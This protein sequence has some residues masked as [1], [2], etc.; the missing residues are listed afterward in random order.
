MNMGDKK[1][2]FTNSFSEEIYNDTYR[3]GDEHIDDTFKRIADKMASNEKDP[4][5]WS[6]NF[7]NLLTNFK[8]VPGGRIISNAGI[9]LRGTSMINC[10]VDGFMGEDQDSMQSI[11][12]ALRR[13]ALI[14]KSEGG[15]G[16]CAD[17]MRPRGS[18]IEGIGSDSPGAVKM[19]EMWDTQSSVI[20]SGSG[21]K[22]NHKGAKGKIRKGAMMV[23]MSCWHPDIEE[24]ITAK[25]TVGRLTKFNMSVL[26]TNDFME[27][28][29]THSKWVLEFPDHEKEHDY[30]RTHWNGDINA[31]K[32]AGKA[33]VVYKTFEDANELYD[34]IMKS[35]YNRN[36]PGVL[37]VDRMNE[38][39]NLSY[40]EHINAT[41]PC[42]VGSTLVLTNIGWI[43]IA[44]LQNYK[45]VK[46]I[47]RDKDGE[48]CESVLKWSGVTQKDDDIIKVEFSNGEH[49]LC[50]KKHKLYLPDYSEIE[51]GEAMK[52]KEKIKVIGHDDILL[53]ITKITDMNYKEDVYDLTATP[54][55]NF[56]T[57][58]NKE[59]KIITE[60]IVINDDLKLN[61]YSIV[62]TKRGKIF[63][64][65]LKEDD[66]I[67]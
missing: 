40:C 7:Y 55:Y 17:V 50:N 24:F 64:Y 62:D 22:N 12:D 18:F 1:T 34:L 15:Y 59:E 21:M 13:Q 27:A 37:F 16:F 20:T 28:V 31:W 45:D 11:M 57:L 2:T 46:I 4:K 36:E 25:Q 61:Y 8:F 35:T 51:M 5:K 47:T 30:Y 33:V 39:N 53:D 65:Q 32:K 9:P 52:S 43:K 63:A 44:N 14:L 66:E 19:L 42:L 67:I 58:L 38:L 29:K 6:E 10:F 49:L 48:L 54:N 41:N 60:P 3:Y 23:T 26:M 56:F